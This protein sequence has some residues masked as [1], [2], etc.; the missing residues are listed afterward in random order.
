[1][2]KWAK[3]SIAS[4]VLCKFIRYICCIFEVGKYSFCVL[5]SDALFNRDTRATATWAFWS[6]AEKKDSWTIKTSVLVFSK[7]RER[8]QVCRS[9]E[10]A[11]LGQE[12]RS[13]Q[14]MGGEAWVWETKTEISRRQ[15]QL[16]KDLHES[17][18]LAF[19]TYGD[20]RKRMCTYKLYRNSGHRLH[21]PSNLDLEQKAEKLHNR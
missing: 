20:T 4:S 3:I 7:M 1:M 8:F 6:L 18:G 17:I 2:K 16:D 9:R 10:Q 13:C 15:S 12:K 5:C 21:C 14:D 11:Q 19:Y